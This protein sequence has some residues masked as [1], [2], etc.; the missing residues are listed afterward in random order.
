MLEYL[1]KSL[2]ILTSIPLIGKEGGK[3]VK[4]LR[5]KFTVLFETKLKL[6][7]QNSRFQKRNPHQKKKKRKKGIE[8]DEELT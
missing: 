8:K 6:K 7:N 4:K 3:K 2:K 1:N 5:I